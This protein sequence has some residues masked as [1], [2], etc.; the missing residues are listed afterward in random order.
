MLSN[1]LCTCPQLRSFVSVEAKLSFVEP[2]RR[3]A[4][5]PS[6]RKAP[7][8]SYQGTRKTSVRMSQTSGDL[9]YMV[10]TTSLY[11]LSTMTLLLVYYIASNAAVSATLSIHATSNSLLDNSPHLA[12][13]QNE[14]GAARWP[15]IWSTGRC[16]LVE[17]SYSVACPVCRALLTFRPACIKQYKFSKNIS[18]EP[19]TEEIRK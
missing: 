12:V 14:V 13:D 7:G 1:Q 11:T 8:I 3:W 6:T 10:S 4:H 19:Q 18:Q 2:G 9:C 17:K 15:Q 16:R 5:S